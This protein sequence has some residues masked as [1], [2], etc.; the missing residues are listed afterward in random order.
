ALP[1]SERAPGAVKVGELGEVDPKLTAPTPPPG[2]LIVKL[3]Y[4]ALMRDAGGKLRYVRGKDLW[5]DEKGAR[6]EERLEATYPGSLTTP[7]AQRVPLWLTEAEWRALLPASPRQGQRFAAPQAVT[8]R[9]CRWHL[10]PLFVYG[11]ANPLLKKQ[12]KAAELTL[13]V[14]RVW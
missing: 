14:E 11:E 7:R 6:T 4:R 13:T 2:A 5:H 8:D 12:V 9:L 1:A 3:Y 10:N